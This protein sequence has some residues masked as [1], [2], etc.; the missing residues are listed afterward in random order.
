MSKAQSLIGSSA[1]M[2]KSLFEFLILDFARY[3]DFGFLDHG[4]G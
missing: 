2:S 3:S 4:L 1:E